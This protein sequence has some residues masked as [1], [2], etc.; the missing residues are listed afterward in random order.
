ML[1]IQDS[2]NE[3]SNKLHKIQDSLRLLRNLHSPAFYFRLFATS[4]RSN[5]G[6][7]QLN[8]PS[9]QDFHHFLAHFLL[10]LRSNAQ[11]RLV[12]SSH[13]AAIRSLTRLPTSSSLLFDGCFFCWEV[14]L[15]G[16]PPKP[17]T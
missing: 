10:F 7:Q 12:W 4:F 2:L 17:P 16:K 15:G 3:L 6:Q 1:K 8:R 5:P 14:L 11:R 13:S 9:N